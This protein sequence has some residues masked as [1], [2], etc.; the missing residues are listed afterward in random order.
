MIGS[1]EIRLPCNCWCASGEDTRAVERE[2]EVRWDNQEPELNRQQQ[3][4]GGDH[5]SRVVG[6]L[7]RAASPAPSAKRGNNRL[8]DAE[9]HPQG[10]SQESSAG[11]ASTCRQ[12]DVR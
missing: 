8:T 10:S 6:D 4:T 3:M 11:C 12:R 1:W 9:C 7:A 2:I 5:K